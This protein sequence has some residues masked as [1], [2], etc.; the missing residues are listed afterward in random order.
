MRV[1]DGEHPELLSRSEGGNPADELQRVAD[2][3]DEKIA[4][5]ERDLAQARELRLR[6][7]EQIGRC[8]SPLTVKELPIPPADS[9]GRGAPLAARP[10][11]EVDEGDE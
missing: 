3:G 5:L 10:E 2:R 11:C 7:G 1:E 4:R 8:A 9:A 6:L